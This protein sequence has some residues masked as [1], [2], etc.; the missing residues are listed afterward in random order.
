MSSQKD[1]NQFFI[2]NKISP[3]FVY[4]FQFFFLS[5]FLSTL[6]SP[7]FLLILSIPLTISSLFIALYLKFKLTSNLKFFSDYCN[8]QL[9]DS[10]VL[11]TSKYPFMTW[12]NIKK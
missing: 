10:Q 1:Q 5:F 7:I 11:Y 8:N 12:K 3:L 4:F 6:I 2:K 9:P